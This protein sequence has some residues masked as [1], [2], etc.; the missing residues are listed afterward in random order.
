M[1]AHKPH[2]KRAD[3]TFPEKNRGSM[4]F[5]RGDR[6]DMTPYGRQNNRDTNDGYGSTN[7]SRN[8]SFD[9]HTHQNDSDNFNHKIF[10]QQTSNQRHFDN[11]HQYDNNTS[12]H[13]TSNQHTSNQNTSNQNIVRHTPDPVKSGSKS[14]STPS[15]NN[16]SQKC[17]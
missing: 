11:I 14:E 16:S 9:R 13:N 5:S 7:Y 3:I 10:N 12:N 17:R 6:Y 8:S 4:N 15:Q 2:T 1:W